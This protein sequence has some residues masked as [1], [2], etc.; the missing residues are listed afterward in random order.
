MGSS[1]IVP[2]PF[3]G[4]AEHHA[5]DHAKDL[6]RGGDSIHQFKK[7][8]PEPT[9]TSSDHKEVNVR[10]LTMM[11]PMPIPTPPMMCSLLLN[12]CSMAAGQ[13]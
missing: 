12:T 11:M 7:N 6:C 2:G 3:D 13:L 1:D 5:K 9:R 4:T 10:S 8:S